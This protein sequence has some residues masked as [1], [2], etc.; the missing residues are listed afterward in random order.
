M[1]SLAAIV[2]ATVFAA[3][4]AQADCPFPKAPE[5]VPDGKTASAEVMKAAMDEFKAYNDAVT[6]YGECLDEETKA[7]AAA[8]MGDSQLR[9]LKTIQAKK[10]NSAVDELRA[11]AEQFNAQVRAFKARG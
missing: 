2:L 3:A 1:K 4:S 11:K 5:N 6:K 7:K 10:Y 9:Q 8:G